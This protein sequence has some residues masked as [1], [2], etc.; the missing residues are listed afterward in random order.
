MDQKPPAGS[1]CIRSQRVS[2]RERL[3][4]L[5]RL[6]AGKKKRG[7]AYRNGRTPG[8]LPARARVQASDVAALRLQAAG[9]RLG[10]PQ[11]SDQAAA[12]RARLDLRGAMGEAMARGLKARS[13]GQKM[14]ATKGGFRFR[15]WVLALQ[16]RQRGC[17][18][19]VVLA[20]GP[21]KRG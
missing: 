9:A 17:G 19:C 14:T 12:G 6:S 5:D 10:L 11:L 4:H 21:N 18:S 16:A 7:G 8:E 13:R 3:F 20:L 1:S 15:E 2:L